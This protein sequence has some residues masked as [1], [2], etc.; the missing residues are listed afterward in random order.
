MHISYSI[1]LVTIL[2][3]MIKDAQKIM[4]FQNARRE[5]SYLYII[6]NEKPTHTHTHIS[7]NISKLIIINIQDN[8]YELVIYY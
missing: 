3:V 7:T 2:N 8:C 6:Y 1:P 5:K 4:Y